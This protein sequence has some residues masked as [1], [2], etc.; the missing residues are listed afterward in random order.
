VDGAVYAYQKQLATEAGTFRLIA[1]YSDVNSAVRAIERLN[2]TTVRVSISTVCICRLLKVLQG[3]SISVGFHKPDL[4]SLSPHRRGPP[5]TP[6]RG[7]GDHRDLVSGMD[8]ISI[9]TPSTLRHPLNSPAYDSVLSPT[10]RSF[11]PTPYLISPP[12][13]GLPI[14]LNAQFSPAGTTVIGYTPPGVHFSPSNFGTDSVFL[15]PRGAWCDM[16]SP[17]RAQPCGAPLSNGR[18]GGRRQGNSRTGNRSSYANSLAGQHNVVDIDRI[19]AGLDVRT[20]VST[21]LL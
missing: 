9:S 21:V 8:R 4:N 14:P 19:R 16:G 11:V 5:A 15:P 17:I 12:C 18:F 13:S 2:G 7:G 20:T 10:G 3:I 1:E 6:T